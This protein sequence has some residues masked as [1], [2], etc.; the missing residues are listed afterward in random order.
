MTERFILLSAGVL[1][2]TSACSG[3]GTTAPAYTDG[4]DAEAEAAAVASD[5]GSDA[6]D[7]PDAAPSVD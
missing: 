4:V 7:P 3:A 1:A 5:D 2:M 6:G